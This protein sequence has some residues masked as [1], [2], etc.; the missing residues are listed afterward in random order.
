MFDPRY[1]DLLAKYL[2][3]CSRHE[4]AVQDLLNHSIAGRH[5]EFRRA[6]LFAR[7][8]AAEVDALYAT[9]QA[10]KKNIP[11]P[12]RAARTSLAG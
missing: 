8:L 11:P 10:A 9:L 2:V 1:E 6:V 12:A 7:T 5:G 3:L 4:D